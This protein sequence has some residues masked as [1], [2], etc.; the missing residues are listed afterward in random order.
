MNRYN[1]TVLAGTLLW[2]IWGYADVHINITGTLR[3]PICTVTGADGNTTVNVF[4]GE[5]KIRDVGSEKVEKSIQLKVKC[6]SMAPNNKILKMKMSPTYN[7]VMNT[8]GDHVLKT[9][10]DGLG[11]ALMQGKDPVVLNNW[12]TVNG[13]DTSTGEPAGDVVL[14]AR[15]VSPNIKAL[16][17]G[18]FRSSASLVMS[19]Q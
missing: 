5:A 6:E 12:L 2:S 9:S 13:I 17:A 4:F 11:I 1:L 16:K 19:Y 15:L 10:I 3:E 7:G 8:L 14:T 18:E